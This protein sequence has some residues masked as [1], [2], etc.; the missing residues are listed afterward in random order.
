MPLSTFFA[1]LLVVAVM[2][3]VAGFVAGRRKREQKP[4][5]D[6]RAEILLIHKSLTLLL[7]E[8]VLVSEQ[9]EQASEEEKPEL[10]DRLQRIGMDISVLRESLLKPEVQH[11]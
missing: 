7:S 8:H 3:F 1:L 11:G 5:E 2:A 10:K 6:I 4:E 9:L